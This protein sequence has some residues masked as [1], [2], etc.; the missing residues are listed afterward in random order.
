MDDRILIDS[1]ISGPFDIIDQAEEEKDRLLEED[2][3][4][5]GDILICYD[6]NNKYYV[7]DSGDIIAEN[8][9][10]DELYEQESEFWGHIFSVESRER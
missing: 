6:D 5:K 4:F 3:D 8:V 2:F 7:C 9:T 10:E 1:Y